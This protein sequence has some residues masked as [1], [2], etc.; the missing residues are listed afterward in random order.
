M[1]G[2][3]SLVIPPDDNSEALDSNLKFT[4][5]GEG[6]WFVASG[7]DDEYYYDGDAMVSADT[8]NNEEGF[9][10]TP[11]G[12]PYLI[13]ANDALGVRYIFF[14]KLIWRSNNWRPHL[15]PLVARSRLL[16]HIILVVL[17][18]QRLIKMI[19]DYPQDAL[20]H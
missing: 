9:R 19:I 5:S 15:T 14:T 1:V 18:H 17:C 8:G 20:R 11:L 12:T 2:T 4:E 10:G 3:G 13:R 16:F 7:P 6:S